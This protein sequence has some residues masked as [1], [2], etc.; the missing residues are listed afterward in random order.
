MSR[1]GAAPRAAVPASNARAE[2]SRKNGAKLRGPKT[3]QGRAR[4]V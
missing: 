4:S 2:A 3:P 1:I